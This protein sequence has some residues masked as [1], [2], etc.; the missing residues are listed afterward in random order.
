MRSLLFSLAVIAFFAQRGPSPAPAPDLAGVY[1]SIS[2]ET[3]LPGGLRNSGSPSEI[4]LLP[5]AAQ[6]LKTVDLSQDAEKMCQPLG[7]FRMMARK[8]TKI[9]LVS[10]TAR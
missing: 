5:A 9:E 10:A 2:D 7:P 8:G 4:A 6:Q 1:Q 3:T